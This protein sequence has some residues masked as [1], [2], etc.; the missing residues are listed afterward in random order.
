MQSLTGKQLA[1]TIYEALE[2]WGLTEIVKAM[3]CDTTNVNLGH[4][5]FASILLEEMLQR[6]L[7]YLPCR[8]LIY[9]IILRSISELKMPTST[10]P[11][12]PIFKRFPQEWSQ[13]NAS[14]FHPGTEIVEIKDLLKNEIDDILTFAKHNLQKE[15]QPRRRL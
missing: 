15:H 8:H 13:I 14:E 9:E 5:N 3:C 12:V 2:N 4:K 11:N 7:L 10:G 6:K 1:T